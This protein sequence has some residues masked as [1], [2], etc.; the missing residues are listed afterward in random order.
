MGIKKMNNEVSIANGSARLNHHTQVKNKETRDGLRGEV[1][2]LSEEH[3]ESRINVDVQDV[4]NGQM[5]AIQVQDRD[6]TCPAQRRSNQQPQGHLVRWER[7]LP[8]RSLR[9]L[10]VEN[11]DS[12]RDIV[13]AL[14]RNCGYEGQ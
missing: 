6:Q 13:S 9:V 11:D 4:N 10:L 5:E 8:F 7:F 3:F 2:G 12:T 1:Q 14:L